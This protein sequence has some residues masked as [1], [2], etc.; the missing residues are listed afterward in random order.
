[1]KICLS[2][3]DPAPQNL[4]SGNFRSEPRWERQ[5]LEA[6]MSNPLVSA[7]YT[8]GCACTYSHPKY[9]G[10][11]TVKDSSSTLLLL[12]DWNYSALQSFPWRAAIINIFAGPWESQRSEVA[13]MLQKLDGRLY[14]TLG[15]PIM[16]R[17]EVDASLVRPE[18]GAIP[19]L[20]E[21]VPMDNVILLPNPGAPSIIEGSS[22]DKTR[23][24]WARRCI[25]ISELINSP[26]LLWSLQQLEKDT[27]LHLD[28]LTGWAPGEAK[29]YVD[30]AVLMLPDMPNYFWAHEKLKPFLHVRDRVIIHAQRGWDEVLALYSQAKLLTAVARGFGGP[31]IE[32]AMHGIP[33]VA[34]G[35]TGALLDC[36]EYLLVGTEEAALP[37]LDRLIS[38]R[39]YYDKVGNSY[40]EYVR[41]TYTYQAFNEN[42]NNI[43]TSRGIF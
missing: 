5:V 43:I 2:L 26:H 39:G 25:Y 19:R 32:A 4:R 37:I 14:L 33:F 40:R 34:I 22:F 27:N 20:G 16:Y 8:I 7:V 9:K 38:D 28:I 35:D 36:P 41:E 24:L 15:F 1:M 23:L 21:Y 3:R 18:R 17:A 11:M 10:A 29:D 12:Q 13:T 30:T 31:P 6:L 42:I